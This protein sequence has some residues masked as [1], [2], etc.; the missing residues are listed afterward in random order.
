MAREGIVHFYVIPLE[1]HASATTTW[2]V[3]KGSPS[4]CVGVQDDVIEATAQAVRMATYQVLSGD[5]AQVHVRDAGATNW[6]TVWC[7]PGAVP[8]FP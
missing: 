4:N 8:R 2:L 5:A 6:R 3:C 7:P 1:Q